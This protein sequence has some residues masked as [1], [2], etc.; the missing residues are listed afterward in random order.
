MGSG[1]LIVM[2][3]DSCMVD[4]AHYFLDFCVDESCGKCPP[5]RVGTV[6][7]R[8]ILEKITRGEAE[9]ADLGRLEELCGAVRGASLCGLGQTAP[10]PI[11]STLRHF[12]HEYEAHI[13]E[14]TCPARVCRALIHF[15][16]DYEACV[17]CGVCFRNCPVN[18]IFQVEGEKK[19]YIEQRDCICC[20]ACLDVCRFDA[21]RKTAA[22]PAPAVGGGPR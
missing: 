13:K 19:F 4:V 7:M 10:N 8:R 21:V 22:A 11:V 5:C 17:G 18:T 16:I 2:D 3:E 12:R 1:G 15:D 20:G 9:M 14:R 6:Q